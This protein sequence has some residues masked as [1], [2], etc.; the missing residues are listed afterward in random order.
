ME[1][2]NKVTEIPPTVGPEGQV[3]RPRKSKI[4]TEEQAVKAAEILDAGRVEA[5]QLR[6]DAYKSR[7]DADARAFMDTFDLNQL[8]KEIAAK[9]KLKVSDKLTVVTRLRNNS[10]TIPA[11]DDLIK[12]NPN[13]KK[14]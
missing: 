6:F 7:Y 11:L 8:V 10:V 5:N 12:N 1:S 3:I 4:P 14:L 13:K 2:K 9:Y